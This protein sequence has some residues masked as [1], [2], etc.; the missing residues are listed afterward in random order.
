MNIQ[1]GELFT[2]KK[3]TDKTSFLTLG[4]LVKS[5]MVAT[6]A[7]PNK[8]ITVDRLSGSKGATTLVNVL[9]SQLEPYKGE[10]S[11]GD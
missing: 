4:E 3:L 6:S 10:V 7:K 11:N 1:C 9:V 8:C 2:I 5:T